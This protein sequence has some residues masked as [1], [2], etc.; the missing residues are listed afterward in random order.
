MK[1]KMF[2]LLIG[3]MSI[4]LLGI[5]VVQA[6]RIK[7]NMDSREDQF[8][9]NA[10]QTLIEVAE[11]IRNKEIDDYYVRYAALPD[12][13]K[14]PDRASFSQ[15]FHVEKNELTN[16]TYILTNSILQEDYKVKSDIPGSE[17]DTIDF[18]KLVNTKVTLIRKQDMQ[19][20]MRLSA[21]ERFE[22]VSRLEENEKILLMDTIKEKT[23]K[24]PIYK[25]VDAEELRILIDEQLKMR[26]I[27]SDF[28]FGIFSSGL[29]TK[30][31]TAHFDRNDE[32]AYG[33]SILPSEKTNYKLFIN[34]PD[35]EK[36]IFAS[37]FWLSTMSFIFTFIIILTFVRAIY[38]LIK[39]RRIDQI[40]TD[41]INNMT[42]EFKTPIATIN[43]AL[44]SVSN[45]KVL[46]DPQ[47][48]NKLL[49]MIRDENHRM[50]AQVENVL[51]ISKLERNELDLK[52][53]R[54]SLHELVNDAIS[55]IQLIVE[56]RQGYINTHLNAE[57]DSILANNSHF[58]N[59]L[60]NILDN[61]VKYSEDF[62]KIDISTESAGN[63]IVLKVSDQGSGMSKYVQ[64]RIFD[65]FYRE[66][67][68]NIHNVKG[69]GLGLSYVKKI[70]ED[71]QGE[72]TV[73]SEKG[74]G[75]TF[76]IKLPII[77]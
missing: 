33:I 58:I 15:L 24:I 54:L 39:Q 60:V 10:T 65:Q 57:K 20:E 56:D 1:K 13:I 74:K 23:E 18:K 17:T 49:K 68:G 26:G 7:Q 35:K 16:E 47:K 2:F 22:R 66:P 11:R 55:H 61:A 25:R 12:T 52:K 38:Q 32:S 70:V 43:L 36:E 75:S 76:I 19:S 8:T 34:F 73:E 5:I 67:T 21:H 69:H 46:E 37:I 29:A 62:P 14:Q 71:H 42:H 31:M 41:F 53:E 48:V 45:P 50:H 3:V 27:K 4:S 40:K 63:Y 30:V 6:Y 44:D 9:F 64:K 72:I 59:V 77:S 28:D 51:R